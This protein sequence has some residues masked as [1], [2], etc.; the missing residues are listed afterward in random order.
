MEQYMKRLNIGII[1]ILL[2]LS[3]NSKKDE[4]LI[5]L[6]DI[7]EDIIEDKYKYTDVGY[8]EITIA[9]IRSLEPMPANSEYFI[10]RYPIILKINENKLNLKINDRQT[11][12]EREITKEY[13]NKIFNIL[14]NINYNEIVYLS[15]KMI[16]AD[17]D[18]IQI[19]IGTF[20]NKFEVTLWSIDYNSNKRNTNELR[21]ILVELFSLFDIKI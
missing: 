1:M 5:I 17:G 12:Y 14:M 11:N 6:N 8:M 18:S 16:G 21:N 19:N 20:Q 4:K 3:C 10:S 9:Y 13:F 15:K 2:L 7:K